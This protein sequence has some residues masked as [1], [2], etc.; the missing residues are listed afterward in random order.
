MKTWFPR[1]LPIVFILALAAAGVYVRSGRPYP[2]PFQRCH[3]GQP[4]IRIGLPG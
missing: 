1:L 2:R 3:R 4:A